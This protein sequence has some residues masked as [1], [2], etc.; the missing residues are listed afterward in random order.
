MTTET[1]ITFS[2]WSAAWCVFIAAARFFHVSRKN[3][4]VVSYAEA[5]KIDVAAAVA[6]A[7]GRYGWVEA[8]GV[9]A[10]IYLVV[11]WVS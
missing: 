5:R 8:V 3:Y 6:A 4:A 2:Q 10:A 9:I 11:T 1:L 7:G